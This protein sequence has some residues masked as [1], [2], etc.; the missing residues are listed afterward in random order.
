MFKNRCHPDLGGSEDKARDINEAYQVLS[1]PNKRKEYDATLDK[2]WFAPKA[3]GLDFM[4]RRRVPRVE[5][6]LNVKYKTGSQDFEAG[7]VL[8]L[9]YLG[10]RLQSKDLLENGTRVT[11]NIGGYNIEGVVRWKRMFHPSIFQRIHEAGVE[12]VREFD[13]ID[14]IVTRVS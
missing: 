6:D 14:N 9:S 11:M 13:E 5:V 12:F 3:A 1:N 7:R 4:E 10:C 8:D 2:E